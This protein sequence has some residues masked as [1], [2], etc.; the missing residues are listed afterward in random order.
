MNGFGKLGQYPLSGAFSVKLVYDNNWLGR[1]DS[2]SQESNL[3]DWL[4]KISLD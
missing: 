1:S 2:Q 3:L 4:W